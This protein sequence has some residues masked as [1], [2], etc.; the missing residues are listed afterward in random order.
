MAPGATTRLNC[1]LCQAGTYWTGS[2]KDALKGECSC[3]VQMII[4]LIT[5]DS[6]F[7]R[8]AMYSSM[9]PCCDSDSVCMLTPR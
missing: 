7:I 5:E 1:S 9:H 8:F 6:E 4:T 2:S 3:A